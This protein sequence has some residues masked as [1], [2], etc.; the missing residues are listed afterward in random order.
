[1][2]TRKLDTIKAEVNAAVAQNKNLRAA[3]DAEL[4]KLDAA[5]KDA[6][7]QMCDAAESGN[8]EAYAA[9]ESALA[10]ATAR[11]E[12]LKVQKIAPTFT[13]EEAKALC[14]EINRA[15]SAE[16]APIAVKL[17]KV[18][19]EYKAICAEL[20]AIGR[21]ADA[22]HATVYKNNTGRVGS[23]YNPPP[24]FDARKGMAMPLSTLIGHAKELAKKAHP[25]G[26]K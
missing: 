16:A 22:L 24:L 1:M 13:K 21:K 12:A 9:A 14:F 2:G 23:F 19:D 11:A 20:D 10:Y 5:I 18:F 4:E 26:A 8:A 25:S 6:R 7:A 15:S 3:A 17:L